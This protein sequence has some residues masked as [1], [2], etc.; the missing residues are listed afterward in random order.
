MTNWNR[1]S[2]CIS[3]ATVAL[4]FMLTGSVG[5]NIAHENRLTFGGP[6]ALPGGVVLPAGT[7][8]FN[9][10]ADTALDV[11]I[12]RNIRGDKVF[13]MGFTALVHRPVGMPWNTSVVLG[14]APSNQAA[15]ITT[16]Y[17]IGGVM[18]HE[19]RY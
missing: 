6:V 19:F 5:A 16:W 18:G 7:Y 11:V 9:V 12:V 2:V 10:A 8:S 15:P 13:Y 3:S 4:A 1:K 14:E 17:E